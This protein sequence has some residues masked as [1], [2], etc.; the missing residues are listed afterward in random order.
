MKNS[1]ARDI[2]LE[3]VEEEA[4]ADL[5]PQVLSLLK[6]QDLRAVS[7]VV[8]LVLAVCCLVFFFG[9]VYQE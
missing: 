5:F 2:T 9:K 6:P 1:S 7:V 3:V 8:R 4:V